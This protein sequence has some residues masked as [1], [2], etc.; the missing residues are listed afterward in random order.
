MKIENFNLISDKL[1]YQ[2][3]KNKD[4]NEFINNYI[5]KNNLNNFNET[6]TFRLTNSNISLINSIRHGCY[7]MDNV[8]Y[9]DADFNNV[10][11]ITDDNIY[12]QKIYLL[13][14]LRAIPIKQD[15][16][17]EAFIDTNIG[18]LVFETNRNAQYSDITTQH[19][20]L[21]MPIDKCPIIFNTF[22]L[23][24]LIYSKST[25][26]IDNIYLRV[27]YNNQN[28]SFSNVHTFAIN[29]D[30]SNTVSASSSTNYTDFDVTIETNG[31]IN[32]FEL[33]NNII[34]RIINKFDKKYIVISYEK[35]Y[36]LL[37]E[38]ENYIFENLILEYS[39]KKK[40]SPIISIKNENVY[41][42][43]LSENELNNVIKD[44]VNELNEFKK[45]INNFNK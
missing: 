9:L 8:Y 14:R 24:Q 21:N 2:N 26:L 42:K 13:N 22:R 23:Y 5:S 20:K 29:T 38:N 4:V 15:K 35:S 31:T 10:K 12:I 6:I 34:D 39:Y 3:I 28:S 17:L 30:E 36:T 43:N 37:Y 40:L 1:I 41:I 7:K 25:L 18:K 32:F 45:L 11:L 16:K 44:I 33:I 19:I 27:G